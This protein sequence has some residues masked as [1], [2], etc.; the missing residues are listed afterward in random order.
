MNLLYKIIILHCLKIIILSKKLKYILLLINNIIY[1]QVS[2]MN[3]LLL[4]C[5]IIHTVL[6]FKENIIIMLFDDMGWADVGYHN[7]KIKTPNLDEM[8]KI[9]LENYYTHP[10]CSP[11]RV[12]LMT[13]KFSFNVGINKAML[14]MNP[15]GIEKE[16]TTMSGITKENNYTNYYIGKWHMGHSKRSYTPLGKSFDYFYGMLGPMGDHYENKLETLHDLREN[17]KLL[18]NINKEYSTHLYTSKAIDIIKNHSKINNQDMFMIISHQVLHTPLMVPDKYLE[19]ESCRN[20]INRNRRNYCGMLMTIDESIKNISM[21]LKES[22]MWDNTYIFGTTDNGGQTWSGALNQPL[23]GI[24]NTL[25]EGGVK[26]VAFIGGGRIQEYYDYHGLMHISDVMPTL[27]GLTGISVNNSIDGHNLAQNIREKTCP[28]DRI[29]VPYLVGQEMT[30]RNNKYKI[31]MNHHSDEY[32]YKDYDHELYVGETLFDKA[33]YFITE[34][35]PDKI[36][37][38]K[39]VVRELRILTRKLIYKQPDIRLYRIDID[40]Q[41]DNDLCLE[42]KDLCLEIVNDFMS[43]I[44]TSNVKDLPYDDMDINFKHDC[45]NEYKKCFLTSWID[46]DHDI[47]NV[48]KVKFLRFYTRYLRKNYRPFMKIFIIFFIIYMFIKN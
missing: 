18:L 8:A 11:S 5:F 46:D 2:N 16:Y 29:I 15:Y 14:G 17:D 3:I 34:I 41:E 25:F 35:I 31:I 37:F 22:G 12:S 28:H 20:I 44:D 32:K 21:A 39:E 10:T 45:D 30:A 36:V 13:G 40:H 42:N 33:V 26:G 48:K 24:K 47:N 4:L 19:M 9:R 1:Y 43:K 38:L 23:R 6:S 27:L 7:P